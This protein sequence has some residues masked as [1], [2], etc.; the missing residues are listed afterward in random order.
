MSTPKRDPDI[1]AM[2]H[3]MRAITRSTPRMLAANVEF[4]TYLM[5]K[6]IKESAA[7]VTVCIMRSPREL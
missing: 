6:L 7:K 2:D 4:V 5:H 1:M 3:A